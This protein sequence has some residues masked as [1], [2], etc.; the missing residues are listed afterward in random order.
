METHF[1]RLQR[2]TVARSA[3]DV[4]A[5]IFLGCA[6]AFWGVAFWQLLAPPALLSL[7]SIQAAVLALVYALATP[8]LWS[9]LVP[10]TPAGQMLQKTQWRTFGFG[11]IV[12]AAFYLSYQGE[13]MIELWLNSQP[14]VAE[15]GMAR[16]LAFS[17]TIAFILI[18]A[19]AW[20][21]LT[22]ERWLQQIQQA[23][24]VK[25]L[26][27]QQRSEL[28]II[29]AR[30][31]WAEQKA[32]VGF[33]NLLPAEQQ[34]V[35]ATL[36]GLFTG[37]ADT[38]RAI[39]RTLSISADLERNVM[40]DAELAEHFDYVANALTA[41]EV[42][43]ATLPAHQ[44]ETRALVPTPI[45]ANGPSERAKGAPAVYTEPHTGH[46][47]RHDA[48]SYPYQEEYTIAHRELLGAWTVK[49]LARVLSIEEPT[50]RQRKAAW[51]DAGLVSGR[52]LST[53]R[54]QFI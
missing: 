29:R 36:R 24:Q 33:A 6:F 53:G 54:Y 19:L 45:R 41:Q 40:G 35:I 46:T 52:G 48:A 31:L 32:A 14:G 25:R 44:E 9:M 42:T 12:A 3:L 39:A 11:A 7:L 27:I 20:T 1:R 37:I 22:P 16:S 49:D 13:W 2:A 18:P 26:E 43:P 5:I 38:Q 21:Q 17:L 47:M 23:H 4:I 10:S 50:A 51:E 28:A 8:L 30:L 34:E 15:N